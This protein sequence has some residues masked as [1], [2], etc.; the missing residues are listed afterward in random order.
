MGLVSR[1]SLAVFPPKDFVQKLKSS[2][3]MVQIDDLHYVLLSGRLI[4]VL[5][6]TTVC[7]FYYSFILSNFT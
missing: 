4:G 2:L 7:S 3:L 1:A 6:E 5:D